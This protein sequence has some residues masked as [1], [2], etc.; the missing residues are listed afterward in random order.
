MTDSNRPNWG[1]RLRRLVRPSGADRRWTAETTAERRQMTVMFVDLVGSTLMAESHEPEVVSD[2]VRRYQDVCGKAISKHAGHIASY[3]GDGVM[4]YFG[5]PAAHEDDAR[6]ATLA[7]LDIVSTLSELG[8]RIRGEYGIDL[9][10]RVGIHTGLVLLT[11]MG[12]SDRPER[13]AVVGATPNEAA[14]IQSVSPAGAVAISGATHEIVRGYFEVESLGRPP[15]KGVPA[16]VEVFRVLRATQAS[17]RLQAAGRALTPLTGRDEELRSVRDHWAALGASRACTTRI[18]LLRGEAGIGK[19][20][21][22]AEIVREVLADGYPVLLATCS[23]DRATSPLHPV[24]RLLESDFGFEAEDDDRSKLERLEL[25]CRAAGLRSADAVPLLGA[26]LEVPTSGRYEPLQLDPRAR[27]E[28]TFEA[29]TGLL[30]ATADRQKTLLVIEDLQWADESTLELIG[31]LGASTPSRG[32]LIMT[33]SRP[34]FR[35]PWGGECFS[36]IDIDRLA[37]DD[38]RRMIRELAGI[39]S[40]SE[41]AW[42]VIAQRSD[43]NP[44]FTEELAR[45]AR[46]DT[47]RRG[48]IQSI[49]MTIRDL[50]TARLDALAQHKRLAQI[51]STIG[52]DVDSD[53]LGTVTGLPR[54]QLA[55][56]LAALVRA[57]ILEELARPEGP[58]SHRFVHA[59]VR[60]AAYESQEQLHDRRAAHLSIAR[61]LLARPGP[62]AGLVAQ[63][64]DAARSV[65][66]AVQYYLR[67]ASA[68][69]LAAAHVEAIRLLDRSLELTSSLSEGPARDGLE[70]NV[71]ILRGLSTVNTQGYAASAAADDYRRGLDLSGRA[72]TDV[73]LFAATAGIWAFYVVHGDLRAGAEAIAR[74]EAMGRPEVEAELLSCTGVQRFFEG[75][76]GEARA[77]FEASVAAFG[78]RPPLEMVSPR[79]QLPSDPYVAA[80]THLGPLAWLDGEADTAQS[81]VEAACRRAAG[82]S[83]PAGPFSQAYAMSYAGWLA[84]LDSRYAD[85][86]ELEEKTQEISARHGLAFWTATAMCH[87]AISRAHMGDPTGGDTLAAGIAQ[88]RALGAEAFVPCL[89]THLAAIR[90]D[91]GAVDD[92]LDAVNRAVEWAQSSGELFFVAESHRIRAAILGRQGTELSVVRGQLETSRRLAAGQGAKLFELRA[93]TDLVQLDDADGHPRDMHDLHRLVAGL[94]ADTR[95][96]ADVVHA[97]ALLAASTEPI[98]D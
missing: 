95:P 90:L 83:F 66:E 19:S 3:A 29:I 71:R 42:D 12:S 54:R 13:N 31:R 30:R 33:T 88:W 4:A 35:R 23:A 63:H 51:A 48:S 55:A 7:G 56:G 91:E 17:D 73:S 75:R 18:V 44:L 1:E 39:H 82:L 28:R 92:A 43:G 6:Q 41:D 74:L 27:R 36:T 8:S 98:S 11:E 49:P 15:M 68:A 22:A 84:N 5:F 81:L 61:A 97:R 94:P 26:L 2:V 25:G 65:E 80:L 14:R 24:V 59:L 96:V 45:A 67:A 76:F 77:A 20:R 85:G 60:D 34:E 64:L 40:L 37:P 16:D 47:D 46:P 53:L 79:W 50:L 62:D 10:A 70:V 72:G 89:Q 32:L 9:A 38:H 78:G 87:G 93:L 57:G 52:R 58:V 69:Q 86:L 21:V